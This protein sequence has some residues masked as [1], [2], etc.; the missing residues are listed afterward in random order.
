MD[1]VYRMDL[2]VEDRVIVEIKALENVLP[3]HKAQLLSYLRLANCR[4]GLLINFNV[5]VLRDGIYRIVNKL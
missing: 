5:E 4:V 1:C 2:F 3:V